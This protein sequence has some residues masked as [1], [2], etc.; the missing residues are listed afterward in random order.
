MPVFWCIQA[1]VE[2]VGAGFVEAKS[3]AVDLLLAALSV[4]RQRSRAA[5]PSRRDRGPDAQRCAAEDR[6][7]FEDWPA[8]GSVGTASNT[9]MS[10]LSVHLIIQAG[11]HC[12]SHNVGDA[13]AAPL[14]ATQILWIKLLTGTA[15]ALVMGVDLPPAEVMAFLPRPHTKDDRRHHI[16]GLKMAASALLAF[17]IGL[18]SGL[19]E[20][21]KSPTEAAPLPE[22]HS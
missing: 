1:V 10:G 6:S 17:D 15:P 8:V 21:D 9:V 3:C 19:I 18:P 7:A 4:D 20:G 16:V 13:V 11:W 12:G 5:K 2:D 14:V 22:P